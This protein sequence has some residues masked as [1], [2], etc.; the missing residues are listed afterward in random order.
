[1]G[2]GWV[3]LLAWGLT[4]VGWVGATIFAGRDARRREA[5]LRGR[6]LIRDVHDGEK[7]ALVGRVILLRPALRAPFSARD[8]ASFRGVQS[9]YIDSGGGGMGG[10]AERGHTEAHSDFEL[11]D[12]TGRARVTMSAGTVVEDKPVKVGNDGEWGCFEWALT[13]GTRVCVVGVARWEHGAAFDGPSSGA[14]PTVGDPFRD[15]PRCLRIEAARL[16]SF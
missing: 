2:D 6:R 5:I 13:E 10:N 11:A 15:A 7:V 14:P 4:C 3:A 12:K 1:M 9:Q 8:G 16:F